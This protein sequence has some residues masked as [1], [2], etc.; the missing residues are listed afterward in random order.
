MGIPLNISAMLCVQIERGKIVK[1]SGSQSGL[2]A[3]NNGTIFGVL[4]G[5]GVKRKF[6]SS[7]LYGN[8]LRCGL[9]AT[10]QNVEVLC[11]R[12]H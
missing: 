1:T 6:K 7:Q 8:E 5:G 12:E 2:H 3:A 4:S 10:N 11:C 9:A